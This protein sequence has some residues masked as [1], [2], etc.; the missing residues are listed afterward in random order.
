MVRFIA[1]IT[2]IS[3]CCQS[4]VVHSQTK[5]SGTRPVSRTQDDDS[6][7]R[8]QIALKNQLLAA[9]DEPPSR[10]Q[11]DDSPSRA[12]SEIPAQDDYELSPELERLLLHWAASSAKIER[13]EGEHLRRVYDLPF[14]IEKLSQGRFYYET[15]DKGRINITPVTIT[16][17]MLEQRTSGEVPTKKRKDGKPFELKSD[18]EECWSCDGSR[19]YE[20]DIAK[21]EA[22]VAQLPTD[23]QGKNIMDSPLPFLFGM[24]PDKAKRRFKMTLVR[25]I[26]ANS[27]R[28]YLHILPRLPQDAGS[29]ASADVILDLK[30]FLPSAVQ[31]M[32]PAGTKITVYSFSGMKV[33]ENKWIDSIFDTQDP[34]T[35]FTP[36]L[37][38]F[39]VNVSDGTQPVQ[40]AERTPGDSRMD[41][42]PIRPAAEK[43]VPPGLVNVQGLFHADAVIQLE[44]QGLKRDKENAEVN[45]IILEAGPPAEKDA[46]IFTVRSQDP[47]PGTPL[48]RGMKVR[49]SIWTKPGGNAKQ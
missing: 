10:T 39:N 6:R 14:E 36:D 21:K 3:V 38:G 44:R 41:A 9:D 25:P 30:T 26:E 43:E 13:L 11:Q 47:P 29:W 19:V 7:A 42:D 16:A 23:L 34:K 45:N 8:A 48:K 31:L 35:R 32:D 22:R 17:Q 12:Q 46:D 4:S 49:I 15:P 27:S 40:T 24:P 28:A 2:L 37:R 5:A 33:N 1:A 18:Q 20:M